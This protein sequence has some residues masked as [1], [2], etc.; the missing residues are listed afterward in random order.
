MVYRRDMQSVYRRDM[1]SVMRRIRPPHP[2]I[3]MREAVID[4]ALAI[5]ITVLLAALMISINSSGAVHRFFLFY[6]EFQLMVIIVNILTVWLALLLALTFYR[7]MRARN[8]SL[9]LERIVSSISPDTLLV[10][11]PDRYV[12][13]CNDSVMRTFG[14]AAHE[15]IGNQTDILYRDRRNGHIGHDEIHD[16]LSDEGFHIGTATGVKKN[17]EEFPLEVIVGNLEGKNG[18]VL[19]LR[20]ITERIRENEE[21]SQLENQ[22]AQRQ[23]MESLGMLAGGIAHD[24]NNLLAGILGNADLILADMEEDT[25]YRENFE[26]IVKCANRASVLCREML[27]YSGKGRM[28]VTPMQIVDVVREMDQFFSITI[29]ENVSIEYDLSSATPPIEGDT[30]QIRQILMNLVTNAADSIKDGRG[31]ITIATGIKECRASDLRT[32]RFFE[33]LIDGTYAFLKISDSG[34]GMDEKTQL[35]IFEPFFTTKFT[36]HGLGLASVQGIIRSH[37]GALDIE[38]APNQGTT[39]TIY[40]PASDKPSAAPPEPIPEGDDWKGDGTALVVD[41]EAPVIRLASRMLT[42]LGF[43]VIS[44]GDGHEALKLFRENQD[45]ISIVLLDLSMPNLSGHE[46]FLEM[47]RVKEDVPIILSSGYSQ[48]DVVSLFTDH[49][50]AGFVQKPYHLNTLRKSVREALEKPH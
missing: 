27:A 32:C 4:L 5:S 28:Q 25:S 16:A 18:A 42:R 44:A 1:R 20:D 13:M 31:S 39:F 33:D 49:S 46:V 48:E 11:T 22:I 9:E 43:D 19:L 6:T 21:R 12:T 50:P 10:V 36:G 34:C 17:G 26:E 7:W 15:I 23:R 40:L 45:D 8:T 29:P 30:S 41:D 47:R 3:A 37:R 35:K 38:S 24:F 14:Y 2:T